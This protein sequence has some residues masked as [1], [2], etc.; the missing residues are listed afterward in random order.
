MTKKNSSHK[1]L[2]TGGLGFIGSHLV[3]R[4]IAEGHDV[5]IIDNL[6]TATSSEDNWNKKA[7]WQRFDIKDIGKL[8]DHCALKFD[9][10]YH[11]AAIARIQPSFKDPE[12]YFNSNVQGTLAVLEYARKNGSKVIYA[13]SSSAFA[14]PYKN[15]YTFTKWQGEELCKMYAKVFG[16]STVTARFFNVYGPR[17]PEGGAYST[18]LGIFQKQYEANTPLTITGDGE[19]RR[20]FTHIDDIVDGI[21]RLSHDEWS[22]EIFSLGKGKNFSINELAKMF[23]GSVEY[24]TSRPG[25]ARITLADYSKMHEKTGWEPKQKLENYVKQWKNDYNST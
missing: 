9:T 16:I 3:D 6:S 8:Q 10:I 15:P 1:V 24:I 21:I 7:S 19:Q 2:V 18:I 14:G 11:M 22:G 5:T 4:L 13:G 20:D 12:S 23:G 25:E 17:Q